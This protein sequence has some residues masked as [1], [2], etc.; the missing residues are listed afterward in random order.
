M[1][2]EEQHQRNH[3]AALGSDLKVIER[4]LGGDVK[5]TS[6]RR[7]VAIEEFAGSLSFEAERFFLERGRICNDPVEE[8]KVIHM[9]AI[10]TC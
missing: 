2:I 5:T 6:T 10:S 4:F 7:N 3:L 8:F 9:K 1:R